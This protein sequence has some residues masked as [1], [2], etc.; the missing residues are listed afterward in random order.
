MRSLFAILLVIACLNASAQT[1]IYKVTTY[2][3]GQLFSVKM[4]TV[5][6]PQKLS[7]LYFFSNHFGCPTS[8]PPAFKDVAHKNEKITIPPDDSTDAKSNGKIHGRARSQAYYT[9]DNN[10]RLILFG[11]TG[12]I[13]C[14]F[15]PYEY[16]VA[17]NKA[18]LVEAITSSKK[19]WHPNRVYH[20]SYNQGGE[21]KQ[22]DYSESVDYRQQIVLVN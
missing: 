8:L 16:T 22:L 19:S 15:L 13:I 3:G 14:S 17:Y 4:D 5:R 2:M 12:C 6:G 11:Q 1:K 10:S 20:I 9:Y 18:G 21:I 7:G